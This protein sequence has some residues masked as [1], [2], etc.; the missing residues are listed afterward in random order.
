MKLVTDNLT[1]KPETEYFLNK[2][3]LE[4]EAGKL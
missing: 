2:V 4:F 1:F 3:S